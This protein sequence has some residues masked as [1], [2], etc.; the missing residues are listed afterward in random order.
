MPWLVAICKSHQQEVAREALKT[1]GIKSYFA[2]TKER[3]IGKRE[4]KEVYTYGLYFFVKWKDNWDDEWVNEVL[5]AEGVAH[6]F[7]YYDQ[8]QQ[9]VP[10][11]VSDH[12]FYL[13][14][15]SCEV[16]G[17]SL[18]PSADCGAV[19]RCALQLGI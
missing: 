13:K 18:L 7:H 9:A 17:L 2:K 15:K 14:V 12:E 19:R 10:N 1:R 16:D 3:V 8:K 4:P 6:V 11:K 5:H